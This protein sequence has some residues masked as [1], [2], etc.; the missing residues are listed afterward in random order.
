MMK[1]AFYRMRS[2]G[3]N[4]G[5]YNVCQEGAVAQL[6]AGEIKVTALAP[7][8]PRPLRWPAAPPSV[9]F[10]S[11]VAV[12]HGHGQADARRVRVG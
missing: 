2:K 10:R 5:A 6:Q 8:V 12:W 11:R 9:A 4:S 3:D 7:P 1:T